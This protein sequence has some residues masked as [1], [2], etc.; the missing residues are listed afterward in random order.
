MGKKDVITKI[1]DDPRGIYIFY[2]PACKYH[3]PYN[4][5][6]VDNNPC[7]KFNGDMI[8]PTFTPSLKCF[9]GSTGTSCHLFVTDGKI[10]YCNDCPHE[11]A[12]KTIDM[13]PMEDV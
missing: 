2:C 9:G 8:K 4:T 13:I 1:Q 12:G 6:K 3:H 5:V 11:M 10:I 7:W